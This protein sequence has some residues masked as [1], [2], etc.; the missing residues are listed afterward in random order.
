MIARVLCLDRRDICRGPILQAFLQQRV[1]P[2]V[3]IE[4][5]GTFMGLDVESHRGYPP[6]PLTLLCMK[7]NRGIDI[8]GH[9][10]RWAKGLN[11]NSFHL[12]V[13]MTRLELEIFHGKLPCAVLQA[14]TLLKEGV[15]LTDAW[16]QSLLAHEFCASQL[17]IIADRIFRTYLS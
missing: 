12:I 7:N 14:D 4:S 17:E 6:S 5:A 13:C 3:K 16:D 15:A 8:S 1:R 10:S 11:L 9:K 2:E